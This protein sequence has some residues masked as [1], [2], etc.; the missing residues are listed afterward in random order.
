MYKVFMFLAVVL[1]LTL[2]GSF[3]VMAVFSTV[4]F[5]K[6]VVDDWRKDAKNN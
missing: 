4:D 2:T 5:V 1:I 6:D 3:V